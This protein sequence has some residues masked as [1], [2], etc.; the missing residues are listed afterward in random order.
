MFCG[1]GRNGGRG[2]SDWG[3]E[4]TKRGK[5]GHELFVEGKE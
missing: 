4:Q 1:V 5:G 2:K 3:G